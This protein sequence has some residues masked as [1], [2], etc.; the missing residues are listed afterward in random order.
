MAMEKA[1]IGSDVGGLL[2]LIQD[3]NTGLIHKHENVDDLAD[4]IVRL[5]DDDELR[6][7]LG[8]N[9]RDFVSEQRA[10]NKIIETHTSVYERARDNW[11]KGRVV[12]NTMARISGVF[13]QGLN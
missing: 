1:V 10:W 3:G 9:G 7:T 4:K 5:I 11:S 13:N 2:E 6:A 12:W 8:R